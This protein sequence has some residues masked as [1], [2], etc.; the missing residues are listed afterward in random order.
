MAG[1]RI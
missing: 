1:F